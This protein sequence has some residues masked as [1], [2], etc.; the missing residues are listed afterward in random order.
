MAVG[1]EGWARAAGQ[2]L[3][4]RVLTVGVDGMGPWKGSLEVAEEHLAVHGGREQ[5]ISRLIATHTRNTGV[6]GFV[7]GFGG[8]TTMVVTLPADISALYLNQGRLIGAVAHL[9][10]YDVKSEEVRSVVLLTLLGSSGAELASEFGVQLGTKATMAL[11]SRVPGRVFI[12]IN[13]KVGFRLITKAGKKGLINMTRLAPVVG[14]G[15]GAGV[16]VAWTLTVGGY[17]KR[18]FPTGPYPTSAVPA[19]NR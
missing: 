12:E 5:A 13:K 6:T 8:F 10:G 18:N 14:A 11:L 3:V 17:A 4:N 1:D 7:T 15:V 16:N 9:R 19:V 2:E